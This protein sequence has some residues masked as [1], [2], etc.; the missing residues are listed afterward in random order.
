MNNLRVIN[1]INN[2][3]PPSAPLTN[4]Y[5][6]SYNGIYQVCTIIVQR[7]HRPEATQLL[8]PAVHPFAAFQ[9]PDDAPK[10]QERNLDATRTAFPVRI[11]RR[12][13]HSRISGASGLVWRVPWNRGHRD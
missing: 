1:V 3:T 12:D 8:F 6:L 2:F 11:P 7:F 9:S 5:S 13:H 4:L 10:N